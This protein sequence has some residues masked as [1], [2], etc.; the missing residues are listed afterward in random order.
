MNTEQ[1]GKLIMILVI[2]VGL[3]L[4]SDVRYLVSE[5]SMIEGYTLSRNILI[6]CILNWFFIIGLNLSKE[7]YL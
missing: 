5:G 4:L 2:L 1:V 3:F 7:K 6:F